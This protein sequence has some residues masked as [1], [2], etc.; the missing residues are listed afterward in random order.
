MLFN[1]LSGTSS[2][3]YIHIVVTFHVFFCL[4]FKVIES[5]SVE[6]FLGGQTGTSKTVARVV[7]C[8][9]LFNSIY[10][11]ETVSVVGFNSR[12]TF[13][14]F[15]YIMWSCRSV[16]CVG[17]PS[18]LSSNKIALWVTLLQYNNVEQLG[19][20]DSRIWPQILVYCSCPCLLNWSPDNR[21]Y[22]HACSS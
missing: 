17:W 10:L 13:M 12:N 9:Q 4:K 16:R 7:W 2:V 19:I 3:M 11:L 18:Q 1:T 15:Q 22:V 8:H 14:H 5:N 6:S 21:E 20:S